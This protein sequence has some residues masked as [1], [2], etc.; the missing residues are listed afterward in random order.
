MEPSIT[1][2]SRVVAL[3]ESS[4]IGRTARAAAGRISDAFYAS[5]SGRALASAGEQW[6]ALAAVERRRTIGLALIIAA[7]VHVG[8][9]L[10]QGA[11]PSWLWLVVPALAVAHGLLQLIAASGP[12]TTK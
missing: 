10:V 6:R 1:V 5:R 12:R 2:T 8:L 11:P 4:L 9:Q 3:V 7:G